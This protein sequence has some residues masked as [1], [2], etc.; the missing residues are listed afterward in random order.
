MFTTAPV[1]SRAQS[2]PWDSTPDQF[3]SAERIAKLRGITRA[4]ADELGFISQKKAQQAWAE[5]RFDRE[6]LHVNAP[7]LVKT[8]NPTARPNWSHAIRVYAKQRWKVWLT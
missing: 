1:S 8:A 7:A 5:G 2:W 4:D 3:A 6:V